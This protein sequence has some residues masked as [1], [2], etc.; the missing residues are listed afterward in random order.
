MKCRFSIVRRSVIIGNGVVYYPEVTIIHDETGMIM[1][2]RRLSRQYGLYKFDLSQPPVA[3][4][5]LL[6]VVN[7]S[8]SNSIGCC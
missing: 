7:H 5:L 4:Q 1:Q 8:I 2:A 6:K 3:I